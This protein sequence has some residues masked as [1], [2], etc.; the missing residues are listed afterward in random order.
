M[1]NKHSWILML[2]FLVIALSPMFVFA[3]PAVS[4]ILITPSNATTLDDLTCEITVTDTGSGDLTITYNW[5][6]CVNAV[7]ICDV[8]L[9]DSCTPS[10]GTCSI[11]DDL[12]SQYTGAAGTD[13][14]CHA[15]QVENTTGTSVSGMS[16]SITISNSPPT[17]S[18]AQIAYT[19]G[20]PIS[21]QATS[22]G[23]DITF[24]IRYSDVDGTYDSGAPTEMMFICNESS[25]FN[26]GHTDY[27]S[28]LAYNTDAYN[29]SQGYVQSTSFTV[30]DPGDV[31]F[32]YYVRLYD[33][34]SY[35]SDDMEQYS[36][37]L[38][39]R[40]YAS[41]V[42]ITPSSP[43]VND[44]L[45]CQYNYN[46]DDSDDEQ[47][48]ALYRWYKRVT[49]IWTLLSVTSSTLSNPISGAPY[50]QLNEDMMCA[51]MVQDDNGLYDDSYV[52]SSSVTITGNNYPIINSF[53]DT[54]L[55]STDKINAGSDV[56]FFVNWT[57]PDSG[58][59]ARLYVCSNNHID[60]NGCSATEFCHMSN[61]QLVGEES[62]LTCNYTVLN[63]DASTVNYYVGVCDDQ[64]Q[65]AVSSSS[66]TFWVNH[67]PEII[68]VTLTYDLPVSTTD[69]NLN[70]TVNYQ[71]TDQ[72]G[73]DVI[74]F[75]RWHVNRSGTVFT[76]DAPDHSVV[77]HGNTQNGDDWRCNVTGYDGMVYSSPVYSSWVLIYNSDGSGGHKPWI[78]NYSDNSY[79]GKAVSVGDKVEF[80][81]E[82][83]DGD[84]G[85][86]VQL[87][88]CNS[89]SI[90][91]TGCF[92]KI[93]VETDWQTNK[94]LNVSY[95]VQRGDTGIMNY[96]LMV[97]D[98]TGANEQNIGGEWLCSDYNTSN[99]NEAMGNIIYNEQPVI[100]NLELKSSSGSDNFSSDA[101]LICDATYYDPDSTNITIYYDWYINRSGV[102]IEILDQ[103][104][105]TLAH[106]NIN[107]LDRVRCVASIKDEYSS[108]NVVYSRWVIIGIE[109]EFG[110][111][112]IISMIDDADLIT[113]DEKVTF[114]VSWSDY[115]SSQVSIYVCSSSNINPT[116]CIDTEFSRTTTTSSPVDLEYTVKEEL[117]GFVNYWVAVCDNE[118]NCADYSNGN[119]TVNHYP[120]ITKLDLVS[121]E[122]NTSYFTDNSNI[123]CDVSYVDLD[124][125][126]V[127]LS[128]KW[129]VYRG[130]SEQVYDTP[131][132][133][134]IITKGNILW[135]DK[136]KCEVTPS[137]KY[138]SGPTNAS[139]WINVSKKVNGTP[140]LMTISHDAVERV[141]VGGV[142]TFDIMWN[143]SDSTN[144]KAYVCNSTRIYETGCYDYEFGRSGFAT[145][146]P[147]QIAYTVSEEIGP[148]HNFWAMVCDNT[149]GNWK[150]SDYDTIS[151]GNFTINHYAKIN[152]ISIQSDTGNFT[153]DV[154]LIC[155][156]GYDLIDEDGDS[157]TINYNWYRSENVSGY[158]GAYLLYASAHSKYLTHANTK[159]GERWKCEGIPTDG[160][161]NGDA[162]L[163]EYV[164]IERY[165]KYG[166]GSN[167][168]IITYISDSTSNIDPVNIDKMVDI[169]VSV[170]DNDSMSYTVHVCSSPTIFDSG[171]WEYQF[172]S[173]QATRTNF[174]EVATTDF[175]FGVK[176]WMTTS[177]NY[178]VM[179]CDLDFRCS[180][181]SSDMIYINHRPTSEN[182]VISPQPVKRKNTLYCNYTFTSNDIG[183][184]DSTESSAIFKWYYIPP[185]GTDYIDA[186]INLRYVYDEFQRGSTILCGAKVTDNLGL[187]DITYRNSTSYVVVN[188]EP[189]VLV[190]PTP[191]YPEVSD[192]ITCGVLVDDAD[193]DQVNLSY[194]WYINGIYQPAPT[195]SNILYSSYTKLD[196]NVTCGIEATDGFETVLSYGSVIVGSSPIENQSNETNTTILSSTP[197]IINVTS[198]PDGMINEDTIVTFNVGW[199]D[200]D[201][202]RF[203]SSSEELARLYICTTEN[204]DKFGCIDGWYCMQDFNSSYML[205]CEFNVTNE[206][207]RNSVYYILVCD[208]SG[209]CSDIPHS[210][211]S[212]NRRPTVSEIILDIDEISDYRFNVTCHPTISD[213]DGDSISLSNSE[214]KW[215]FN[216]SLIGY[217]EMPITTQTWSDFI[218]S[219]NDTVLCGVKVSDQFNLTDKH[220]RNS[221][222]YELKETEDYQPQSFSYSGSSRSR[223]SI[224]FV[225]E[226]ETEE[227]NSTEPEFGTKESGPEEYVEEKD[228][229]VTIPEQEVEESKEYNSFSGFSAITGSAIKVDDFDYVYLSY[230][231]F[232]GLLII[233]T[234]IFVF[235][236][237]RNREEPIV[238]NDEYYEKMV[239]RLNDW[240]AYMLKNGTEPYEIKK[241]LV[242]EGWN[243]EIVDDVIDYHSVRL[244]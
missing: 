140:N 135:D 76:Y 225:F 41:N 71:E 188:S 132:S 92:D 46:D 54:S 138:S 228:I 161:S 98:D 125:D 166:S 139:K 45:T 70:C 77:T 117:F 205:S 59:Y 216:N 61:Q 95:T 78:V 93:F 154:N 69:A 193:D 151:M 20:Q 153:E 57:D 63:S 217:E 91:K 64:G 94:T 15:M 60:L 85:E 146:N 191:E 158:F 67:A 111:P 163:S 23:N 227:D 39:Q 108:G 115:D 178:Y 21:G 198:S 65:C 116:G 179:A 80:I 83:N 50:F 181:V 48:P 192:T 86:E 31:T 242:D 74:L 214:F 236:V 150:C 128:Y 237:I 10:G 232:F 58:E 19:S 49:N 18:S 229:Q 121:D 29:D 185:D 134:S 222:I 100:T 164:E 52:N 123:I 145:S 235:D 173:S 110:Y 106:G 73:D 239:T 141:N 220:Y 9:T 35:S 126:D 155:E 11:T 189:D 4:N 34:S 152:N 104:V 233:V 196:D 226:N 183:I 219:E 101:N 199:E 102:M 12:D 137:D 157:V 26:C 200:N 169:T 89:S 244:K 107:D 124:G 144:V 159:T 215:Y 30:Y 7:G 40:P 148:F 96:W 81:V 84:I 82:W 206:T 22:P 2:T 165:E 127:T 168:P 75:Y 170:V 6:G 72:D 210:Y 55:N 5:S 25:C 221:S 13:V 114:S 103:T 234:L 184:N 171:C 167:I 33:G 53:T 133:A 241:N 136:W 180:N 105:N 177:T 8:E 149:A 212:A 156:V 97:C 109:N 142:I 113:V 131:S 43:F 238:E 175:K 66:G 32:N 224:F 88:I 218:A 186:I 162:V 120:K 143:D 37:T 112:E 160:Y 14:Y 44:T 223:S 209:K 213:P 182:V 36:F 201:Q 203:N 17:I 231:G 56:S 194:Y 243:E 119:F 202:Q 62:T 240:V 42:A 207:Q 27:S 1:S 172:N 24:V 3:L 190:E 195:G 176:D 204:V 147:I 51:V 68:S 28:C 90:D 118:G 187:S 79:L 38:N 174:S 16:Q 47:T 211:F 208:D 197:S 99:P 87:Y 122:D 230:W 130:G 129:Y